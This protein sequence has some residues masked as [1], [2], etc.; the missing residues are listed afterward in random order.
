MG[1]FGGKHN[2]GKVPALLE[3]FPYE[4]SG[5]L[6]LF[7]FVLAAD[8][9]EAMSVPLNMKGLNVEFCSGL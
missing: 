4:L 9:V 8:V 1:G 7:D 3:D 2:V 5:V 6:P